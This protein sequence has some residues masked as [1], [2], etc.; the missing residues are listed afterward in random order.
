MQ[1]IRLSIGDADD[2]VSFAFP[3]GVYTVS[4]GVLA[5]CEASLSFTSATFGEAR[6]ATVRLYSD[7]EN[8]TALASV[9]RFL[10]GVYVDLCP[11]RAPA[12]AL[13]SLRWRVPT[14]FQACF[15]VSEPL[16]L[17]QSSLTAWLPTMAHWLPVL[18]KHTRGNGF[19]LSIP[20]RFRKLFIRRTAILMSH[21]ISMTGGCAQCG[22]LPQT[23]PNSNCSLSNKRGNNS[24]RCQ[25]K[26]SPSCMLCARLSTGRSFWHAL[27]SA[28]LFAEVLRDAVRLNSPAVTLYIYR[29]I[30][31]I[32]YGELNGVEETACMLR[33]TQ[34]HG[35][36]AMA[37]KQYV[38]DVQRTVFEDARI[39]AVV[40][41]T[42]LDARHEDRGGGCFIG[43]VCV[44]INKVC[45]RVNEACSGSLREKSNVSEN[46]A[47]WDEW[48]LV[49]GCKVVGKTNDNDNRQGGGGEGR[50]RIV[51]HVQV[52]RGG[53]PSG[54]EEEEDGWE[55]SSKGDRSVTVTVKWYV[56]GCACELGCVKTDGDG[57]GGCM[58]KETRVDR[59]WGQMTGGGVDVDIMAEED[60]RQW[61]RR[62]RAECSL[63]VSVR[64]DVVG[65]QGREAD[66]GCTEW[67]DGAEEGDGG[68]DGEEREDDQDGDRGGDRGDDSD[69]DSQSTGD[70]EESVACACRKCL[71]VAMQ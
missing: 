34:W 21:L 69:C 64:V 4:R 49:L 39:C 36:W 47:I 5:S 38:N 1:Q 59:E 10:S 13:A 27:C 65:V 57:G 19:L 53:A 61:V 37:A 32:L 51:G 25:I 31:I 28:G 16:P 71:Q 48:R 55:C 68:G 41:Q 56:G 70:D 35:A 2:S 45:E 3:D 33:S 26:S 63:H 44:R 18:D 8:A 42:L 43:S 6:F 52:Q 62:H 67:D 12:V 7:H 15:T 9:V 23:Y 24:R 29:V 40:M 22:L 30:M 46:S 17:S 20:S 58:E 50:G 54:E 14:L 60:V 11:S 66:R